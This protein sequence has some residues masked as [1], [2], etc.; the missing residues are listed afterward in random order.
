M[1]RVGTAQEAR[2][3]VAT[4]LAIELRG[5]HKH[6]SLESRPWH[7]LWQQL[8]G[9]VHKGRVHQAL[10]DINLSVRRGEVVGI[11]GRNGAGKSTLLQLV[12]GVLQPSAGSRMV[13]GRIAA[14]LELGAGFNGELTG[15]ENVRLNGPLLGLTPTQVEQRLPQ[16][17]EFAGIGEFID[18]PVR[19]YSSGMFMRLAF[20]MAT[21]V[22]PEILIID[23]AMSVGDDAFARKSFARI[24]E[25]KDRGVTILFC[26]H[27]LFQVES[28]CAR[29][30]WLHEGRVAFDGAAAQ[31]V[32]EYKAW[33]ERAEGGGVK[34]R[35]FAGS[36]VELQAFDMRSQPVINS[37]EDD[38]VFTLRLRSNLAEPAPTLGVVLHGA[39]GRSITAAGSWIDGVAVPRDANGQS[40][41]TLSFPKLALL[42]GHYTASAYVMCERALDVLAAAEHTL[43]FEVQQDHLEQGVVSLPRRWEMGA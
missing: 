31:A 6:Y 19:S 29:A 17:I 16:I 7:R 35:Q 12:C 21:S 36:R 5:V 2:H 3:E 15:R 22:E 32:V 13:R 41:V 37:G 43:A 24:M 20:A 34:A 18:Q 1:P 8:T 11:I 30:I 27:A 23:E 14:L 40:T 10:Q 33:S 39:D 38:L 9:T 42:K 25:L 28:L 26:S 4:D